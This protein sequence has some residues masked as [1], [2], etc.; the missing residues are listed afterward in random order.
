[1]VFIIGVT[2]CDVTLET[3]L[4]TSSGAAQSSDTDKSY[5]NS[6]VSTLKSFY[7]LNQCIDD[8]KESILPQMA[9]RRPLSG[10]DRTW[11]QPSW[12]T[13]DKETIRLFFLSSFHSEIFF[14]V[15][16]TNSIS[17]ETF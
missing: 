10:G 2:V 11:E 4:G 8:H 15:E 1:M 12:L 5:A 7:L 9:K 17:Q 14:N 3:A 13:A 16:M 6:E